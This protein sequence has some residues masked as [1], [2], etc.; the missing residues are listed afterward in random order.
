MKGPTRQDC[1]DAVVLFVK[2][3]IDYSKKWGV[4]DAAGYRRFVKKG[5]FKA[6]TTVPGLLNKYCIFQEETA[7]AGGIYTF[8]NRDC[9]N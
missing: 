9:M 4:S 8:I 2:Y 6:F 5:E 3:R 7:V 1:V